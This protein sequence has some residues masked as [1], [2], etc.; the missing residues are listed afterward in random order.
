MKNTLNTLAVAFAIW[1]SADAM[2]VNGS[3]R[4]PNPNPIGSDCMMVHSTAGWQRMRQR[5]APRMNR[6]EI[7]FDQGG[8][9]VDKNGYPLVFPAIG[10][11]QPQLEQYSQYKYDQRFP[12]GKMLMWVDADN[13][14]YGISGGVYGVSR[15]VMFR[16][17]DSDGTLGDNQGAVRVCL[18]YFYAND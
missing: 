13:T 2:G 11:T 8:W 5:P 18:R 15:G 9:T 12:F 16:I 10:H 6:M 3:N 14:N 4:N 17:N 1:A 7:S